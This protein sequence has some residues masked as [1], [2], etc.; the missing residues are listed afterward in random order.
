[1]SL[2]TKSQILAATD[3][4]TRDISVPEWGGT[5]RVRGLSGAER[6]KFES[7]FVQFDGKGNRKAPNLTHLR[8]RLVSMAAVDDQGNLMFTEADILSLSNKS[9]SALQRVADVAQAMSG[10]SD[11]D[12]DEL[13]KNS[14]T[15]TIDGS[16]SN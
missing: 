15:A 8:A 11:K 4:D 16:T 12:V 2:L 14:K 1:M 5:V 13:T 9:A 6:D 3:I 10:L 7:S